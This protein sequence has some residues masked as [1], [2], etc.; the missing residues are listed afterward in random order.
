MSEKGQSGELLGVLRENLLKEGL[1]N[2]PRKREDLSLEYKFVCGTR[3]VRLCR[4]ISDF[5][6]DECFSVPGADVQKLSVTRELTTVGFAES[7]RE[8][9]KLKISFFAQLSASSDEQ[10]LALV[11]CIEDTFFSEKEPLGDSDSYIFP[12]KTMEGFLFRECGLYLQFSNQDAIPS[13]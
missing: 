1:L 8:S 3:V 13:S 6:Q 9:I 4:R 11:L 7:G 12:H 10:Q 5:S 2:S